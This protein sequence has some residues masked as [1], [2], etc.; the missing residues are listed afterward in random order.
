MATEHDR[1]HRPEHAHGHTDNC[2]CH[3]HGGENGQK[4][5]CGADCKCG[6]DCACKK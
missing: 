4:C 3:C 6:P 1:N 2:S 5:S